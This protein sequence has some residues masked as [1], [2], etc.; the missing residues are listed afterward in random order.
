MPRSSGESVTL[1]VDGPVE[2]NTVFCAGCAGISVVASC[3]PP[4]SRSTPLCESCTFGPLT[5]VGEAIPACIC[6][7]CNFSTATSTYSSDTVCCNCSTVLIV[8]ALDPCENVR[9]SAGC[10]AAKRLH[11][12][13][14]ANTKRVARYCNNVW[15]G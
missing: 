1:L 13:T 4:G 7:I 10:A 3:A 15:L 11:A 2:L 6:F 9:L 8:A 14:A 5:A 12:T